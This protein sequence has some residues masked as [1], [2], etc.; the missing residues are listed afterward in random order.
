MRFFSYDNIRLNLN[1]KNQKNTIFLEN[2]KHYDIIPFISHKKNFSTINLSLT[3]NV[4]ALLSRNMFIQKLVWHP[5]DLKIPVL[6]PNK[7]LPFFFHRYL[8]IKSRSMASSVEQHFW[9][10]FNRPSQSTI[11][12]KKTVILPRHSKVHV[13]FWILSLNKN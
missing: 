13:R 3:W 4:G 2:F 9:E 6:P 1:K 11:N 5:H 8:V 12:I 7:N 10:Q